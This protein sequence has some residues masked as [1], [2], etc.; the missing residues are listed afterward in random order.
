MFSVGDDPHKCHTDEK[1]KKAASDECGNIQN[2]K[3]IE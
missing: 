2:R 1:T 3:I